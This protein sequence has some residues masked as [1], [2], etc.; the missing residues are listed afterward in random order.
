MSDIEVRTIPFATFEQNCALFFDAET[1]DGVVVDPGGNIDGILTAIAENGVNGVNAKA[2]WL[3]HGHLDHVGVATELK[4]RFGVEIVGPHADDLWLL[5]TV[6]KD[7]ETYGL[8]PGSM[9]NV[10][11]DRLLNE[12]DAVSFGSHVFEVYHAPGHTPGHVIFFNRQQKLAHLGD[13]MFKGAIGPT[14]FSG[15]DH[16]QLLETIRTKVLPLGDDVAFICGHGPDRAWP[17]S[18]GDR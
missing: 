7:A 17:R 15:G 3:T 11:P 10:T 8:P 2:I 16:G 5:E 14:H 6:E 9:R 1:R 18:G 13:V 4:E 12:G